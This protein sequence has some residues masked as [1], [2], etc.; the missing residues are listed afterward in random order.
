MNS[1]VPEGVKQLFED[2][3][4]LKF[5]TK[6]N[7]IGTK[8]GGLEIRHVGFESWFINDKDRIRTAENL[9]KVFENYAG[10][11]KKGSILTK[12]IIVDNIN[13]LHASRVDKVD[14]ETL[15][16][17]YKIKMATLETLIDK[18]ISPELK[19]FLRSH[20]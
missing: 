17:L 3:S 13:K 7:L 11:I 8:N 14:F 9:L 1:L 4:D 6:Y 15:K 10:Y 16:L 5:S 12:N 2:L 18:C 20:P 19:T